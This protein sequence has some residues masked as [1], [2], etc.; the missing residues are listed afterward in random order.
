MHCFINIIINQTLFLKV[1]CYQGLLDW[2]KCI[3]KAKNSFRIES[4]VV[5]VWCF[6]TVVVIRDIP[7]VIKAHLVKPSCF[8][9]YP[10]ISIIKTQDI[11][12]SKDT[13]YPVVISRNEDVA[14]ASL[15]YSH[16][17]NK[18]KQKYWT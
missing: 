6:K 13:Y 16:G 10:K 2:D 4:L 14:S 3:I 5:K 11:V 8:F 15:L 17:E 9:V 18:K 7:M 1:Y 12:M